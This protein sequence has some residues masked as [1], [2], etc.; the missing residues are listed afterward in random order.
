MKCAQAGRPTAAAPGILPR[1]DTLPS[2]TV[3]KAAAA[4]R[5]WLDSPPPP[6]DIPLPPASVR[7]LAAKQKES[8]LLRLQN[9]IHVR[10]YTSIG[11]PCTLGVQGHA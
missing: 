4:Y 10:T 2:L 9:G 7:A 5:A 6:P 3:L 8:S 1:S 11:S